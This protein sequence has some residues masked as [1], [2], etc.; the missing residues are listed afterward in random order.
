MDFSLTSYPFTLGISETDLPINKVITQLLSYEDFDNKRGSPFM[1][2]LA[3]GKIR[4]NAQ[5]KTYFGLAKA[6]IMLNLGYYKYEE[7]TNIDLI[8]FEIL[9]FRTVSLTVRVTT[10]SSSQTQTITVAA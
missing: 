2:A 7:I 10:I 1:D 8:T 5:V 6:R 4:N 3:S 9:N